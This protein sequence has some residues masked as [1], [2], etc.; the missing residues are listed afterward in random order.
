MPEMV[1][2]DEERK[3]LCYTKGRVSLLKHPLD[4]ADAI[5]Q[6]QLDKAYP[7]AF[8]AGRKQGKKEL[9]EWLKEHNSF[10]E[11]GVERKGCGLLLTIADYQALR[12]EVME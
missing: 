8:E 11:F 4:V 5:A 9:L 3:E 1:L 12:R 10:N 6:A 7:I 2:T